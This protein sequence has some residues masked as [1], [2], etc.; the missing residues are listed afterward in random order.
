L[1]RNAAEFESAR[2]DTLGLK[3]TKTG[4]GA[5]T[6]SLYFDHGLPDEL[7]VIFIEYVHRHLA[8]SRPFV[9]GRCVGGHRGHRLRSVVPP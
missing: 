5:P 8:K 7:K 3:I 4:D 9:G 1:W 6:I 2:K